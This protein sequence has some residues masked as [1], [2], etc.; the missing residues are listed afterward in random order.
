MGSRGVHELARRA[1]DVD[2]VVADKDIDS[3]R[4]LSA[5]VGGRTSAI[6]V[7]ADD[8]KSLVDVLKNAEVVATTLGPYY[9][10]GERVLRAA[11]EAK[12]NLVDIND[13]QDATQACLN[14]DK[15]AQNAGITAIIC[16]GATPGI[17]NV[18]ARYGADKL[19][20]VDDIHISW[21]WT[22]VG[23][24]GSGL[25]IIDHVFHATS[26]DILTYRD[27][28]LVKVPADSE[29]E[30]M[31]FIPPVGTGHVAHFGH[32]EPLT[33]PRYIKV[34]NVCNKGGGWPEDLNNFYELAAKYGLTS[35]KEVTINGV[36]IPI[37]TFT[38][39]IVGMMPEL[40]PETFASWLQKTREQLGDFG[41]EGA[42]LRVE[43]KG[44]KQGKPRR[45]TYFVSCPE[46]TLITSLPMVLGTLMLM[47]GQI[48]KKG[49]FAPEGIID[50]EIF[51]KELAKDMK[52]QEHKTEEIPF[53]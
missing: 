53:S 38:S 19:D 15:E 24:S 13:D 2:L 34:K 26:G 40:I 18:L 49:V 36:S 48:K 4:K 32:P 35:R 28:K 5:E 6:W 37:R 14:L 7:D 30:T 42:M 43:I 41:I 23:P 9:I 50:S 33:I 10:Y 21:Y 45:Y 46:E 3:A 44:A 17:T 47:R 11:I 27:G 39:K 20:E 12:T 22:T 8:F 51:L 25:A 1:P 16:L 29:P 31:E 52:I